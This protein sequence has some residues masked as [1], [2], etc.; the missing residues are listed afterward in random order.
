M[1]R[2]YRIALVAL[3]AIA[4]A[5]STT[6]CSARPTPTL[7]APTATATDLPTATATATAMPTETPTPL[8]TPFPTPPESAPEKAFTTV[9]DVAEISGAHSVSGRAIVSGLQTLIIRGF[10]YDGKGPAV[11]IRLVK[12]DQY[13]QPVA[14]LLQLEQR[15]YTDEIVLVHIPSTVKPDSADHI[16]IYAPDTGEVYAEAH[17]E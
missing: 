12:G 2:V 14:I 11:D 1:N 10:N 15:A 17:F 6:A 7:P 13:D 16:V 4:I 9:G 5:A 3:F 8:P